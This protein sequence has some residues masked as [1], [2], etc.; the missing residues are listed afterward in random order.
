[1]VDPVMQIKANAR[2]LKYTL[3]GNL[4]DTM[5]TFL[6]RLNLADQYAFEIIQAHQK[7]LTH[8][9]NCEMKGSGGDTGTSLEKEPQSA[10][11]RYMNIKSKIH[12]GKLK[13]VKAQE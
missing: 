10:C 4:A 13:K 12:E 11:N 5:L 6:E 2:V 7:T 8:L 3:V 1:M 9:V